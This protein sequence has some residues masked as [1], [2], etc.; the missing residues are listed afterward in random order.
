[1]CR[2]FLVC[3]FFTLYLS[4]SLYLPILLPVYVSVCCTAW[5][6]TLSRWSQRVPNFSRMSLLLSHS[7]YLSS[8]CLSIFVFSC[9]C[10]CMCVCVPHSLARDFEQMEPACADYFSYVPSS[11]ALSLSFFLSVCLSSYSLA[12]VCVSVCCTAW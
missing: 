9:L 1:V 10:V 11:L 3:S 2:L 6:G 8:V 12:C 7:L 5:P 4:L